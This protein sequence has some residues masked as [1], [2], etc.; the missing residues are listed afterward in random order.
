VARR[1]RRSSRSRIVK[2]A[3]ALVAVAVVGLFYARPLRSYLGV[4]HQLAQR[5]GQVRA[6]KQEKR[7][8][9]HHLA[10]SAT[11]QAL[12]REAR[13]LGLVH[14]GE[15]LFIVKGISA[16]L[17]SKARLV[18]ANNPAHPSRRG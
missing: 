3:L 11:P 2:P 1:A 7:E 17:H 13:R 12:T 8:L 15:R 16:W 9:Q 14:P 4:K 5:A 6:L 18:T 10:E